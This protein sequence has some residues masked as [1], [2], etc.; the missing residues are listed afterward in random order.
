[1]NER[2][3]RQAMSWVIASA[4]LHPVTLWNQQKAGML[5]RA[6][7]AP[8]PWP[9]KCGLKYCE[10]CTGHLLVVFLFNCRGPVWHC[11]FTGEDQKQNLKRLIF[12]DV[13]KIRETVKRGNG[14]MTESERERLQVAVDIGRGR[15][16]LRLSE[17]Q[18]ST[19]M[20]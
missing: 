5:C 13:A 18:Y 8:L 14:I 1:M 3:F 19:L 2:T 12:H 7:E 11:R 9:H 15:I 6:C 20:R 4:R 10:H 16:L 17:S